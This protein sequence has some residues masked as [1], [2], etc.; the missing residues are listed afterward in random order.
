MVCKKDIQ[1][2]AQSSFQ[3]NFNQL[4]SANNSLMQLIQA[5]SQSDH[6]QA[7]LIKKLMTINQQAF[8]EQT[9]AFI[10]NMQQANQTFKII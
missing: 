3:D 2:S 4:N 10:K 9:Q 6:N 8:N 5:Q 1:Q 7:A